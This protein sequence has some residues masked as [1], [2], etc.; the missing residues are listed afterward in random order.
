M[1]RKETRE[2]QDSETMMRRMYRR[3]ADKGFTSPERAL[4]RLEIAELVGRKKSPHINKLIEHMVMINW[5]QKKP[6]RSEHNGRMAWRYWVV[7]PNA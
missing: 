1:A 5:L 4:T 2:Y 7:L 6:S 3:M